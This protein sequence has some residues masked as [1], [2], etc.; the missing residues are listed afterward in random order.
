M[1]YVFLDSNIYITCAG[2]RV[3]GH[4]PSLLG[5]LVKHAKN[6]DAVLLVPEVVDA[7]VRRILN[8]GT[9]EKFVT[10]TLDGT[11]VQDIPL[12]PEAMTR[13]MLWTIRGD[14]PARKNTVAWGNPTKVMEAL[15]FMRFRYG[16]E[17]DCLILASLTEFM[18]DKSE[19]ELV[20]CTSDKAWFAEGSLAESIA[21]QFQTEAA[22]YDDLIVLL[23]DEFGVDVD[24]E[25]AG[26][27]AGVAASLAALQRSLSSITLPNL[28]GILAM[29][30]SVQSMLARSGILDMQ[31]SVQSILANSGI[32]GMQESVQ[33]LLARSGIQDTLASVESIMADSGIREVQA[34]IQSMQT[35]LSR[36]DIGRTLASVASMADMVNTSQMAA[37]SKT[38]GTLGSSLTTDLRQS[39]KVIG[40]L[41][42]ADMGRFARELSKQNEIV[43]R[44]AE[45]TR[46]V[47]KDD[48]D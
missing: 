24:A 30:E 8:G 44:L 48:T 32:Q 1:K 47:Q 7:E 23:K 6:N 27:Y 34:S 40:R 4:N 26:E 37:I 45:A 3:H 28:Q 22:A 42:G 15:D 33:S 39:Q 38:M 43:L 36:P 35:M 13:A 21:N 9:N 14:R 12:T 10:K 18:A 2:L 16:V 17:Q 31:A 20:I 11:D 41:Y 5:R 19:D 46:P 29:Q 25:I